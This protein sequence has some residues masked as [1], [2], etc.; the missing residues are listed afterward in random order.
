VLRES[1]IRIRGSEL[2]ILI[3]MP[4]FALVGWLVAGVAGGWMVLYVLWRW[5]R[6]D[7]DA[8]ELVP[9]FVCFVYPA[10]GARKW[11]LIGALLIV[12]GPILLYATTIEDPAAGG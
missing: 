7:F 3:G 11:Q 10:Q 5:A 9:A 4:A 8:M 2:G 1:S 6:E 12:F